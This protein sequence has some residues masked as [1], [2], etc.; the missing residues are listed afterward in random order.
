MD[1]ELIF[2]DF[3]GSEGESGKKTTLPLGMS[4][5]DKI[6][7]LA[8]LVASGEYEP[9]SEKTATAILEALE[10]HEASDCDVDADS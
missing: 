4:K 6:K 2:L 10:S 8:E 9:D 7:R 5:E 1:A 3:E